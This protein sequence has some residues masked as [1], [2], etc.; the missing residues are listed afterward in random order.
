MDHGKRL[1]LLLRNQHRLKLMIRIAI[2]YAEK[3]ATP[4][5][6]SNL[7]SQPKDAK[8][9]KIITKREAIHGCHQTEWTLTNKKILPNGSLSDLNLL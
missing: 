1:A 7:S 9:V 2:R 4:R 5:F 6:K 3:A 8:L